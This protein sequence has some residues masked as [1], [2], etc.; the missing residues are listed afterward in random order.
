MDRALLDKC[1]CFAVRRTAR[2]LTQMYDAALAPAGIRSTQYSLLVAI[3][4]RSDISVN[5]LANAMAMD[6]TTMGRNLRLLERDGLVVIDVA[7]SDRR[8]LDISLTRKGKTLL[9]GAYPLWKHAHD[10]LQKRHGKEFLDQFRG[11]LSQVAPDI[12]P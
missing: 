5:D 10:S 12:E 8:R 2:A 11:M 1:T 7:E 3:G 6:R 9:D 4:D